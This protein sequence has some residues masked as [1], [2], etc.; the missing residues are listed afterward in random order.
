MDKIKWT[1]NRMPK[2]EDAQLPVMGLDKVAKARAFHQSFPQYSQTPL[3]ELGGHA[4]E[5]G[6]KGLYVKDES[7]RFGLNAFKV[8]GLAPMPSPDTLPR[9][10]DCGRRR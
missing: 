5:L 4:K 2:T 6:L 1:A 9:G 10:W 7:Y 8:L 3:A